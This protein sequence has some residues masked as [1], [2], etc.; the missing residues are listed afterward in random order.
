MKDNSRI[1]PGELVN[2]RRNE[3][4]HHRLGAA[5]SNLDGV[6][7]GQ[8]AYLLNSP[9]QFI[10]NNH[11]AIKARSTV[12]RWLDAARASLQQAYPKRV[13]EIGNRF[14]DDRV[15]NGKSGGRLGNASGL[16]NSHQD[17][18]VAQAHATPDA[19]GPLHAS[20]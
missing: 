17:M 3:V 15:R 2:D 14:R 9:S 10:E 11:S 6:R 20:P 19:I 12:H 18:K 16:D 13:F 8:K 1:L 5:D 4:R 7:V